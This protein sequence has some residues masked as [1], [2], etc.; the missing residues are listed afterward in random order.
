M[1]EHGPDTIVDDRY[2]ILT[3]IGAGGM[4]EVFCAHDESLGRKVA[5]KLLHRRFA[6]DAEF[7]ERFRREAS[8]AAGLQHPNVV[9][10]Y[11]RGRWDG[12][13]YIAMEYLPGRT[14]KDIVRDEAPLDPV[15][16]I[17]L[18]VQVLKAARFAHRR[19]V[20]HR[21]LK[22]HNVI[23][24]DEDRAK[25]ADFGIARAGA[26][27]MT[28]TGSIMGTAQYLSPEQAQGQAVTGQSDLYSI[29]VILYELLTG[30]VP[31]QA[32]SAVSIALKHVS[33]PPTPPSALAPGVPPELE[34]VVLWALAK[35]PADR[36]PDADAF[37][38]ALEQVR[39]QLLAAAPG[40]QR[41]AHFAPL[42]VAPAAP[43][44]P[45][46]TGAAEVPGP[47]ARRRRPP[48]WAWLLALVAL[49][50]VAAAVA[51]LTRPGTVVVPDVVGREYQAATARLERAGLEV[52]IRRVFSA[53]P[54]DEVV[55]QAPRARQRV[56]EGST[57]VLSVSRGPGTID[58]P[59]VDGMTVAKAKARLQ[60]DGLTVGATIE[61]ASD[62]VAAGLVIRTSPPAGRDVRKGTS[63]NLYVSTGP[64]LVTVPSVVG[65]ARADAEAR[66]G[67]A[68]L[69]ARAVEEPS[70]EVPAGAV[71]R[72][73]PAPDAAVAPGSTVELVV[74]SGPPRVRVPGVVGQPAADAAAALAD[75]GLQVRRS[76]VPVE[77]PAQD[78]VVIDQRP[79]AGEEAPEGAPVR[80][81]VGRAVAPAPDD[82]GADDGPAEPRTPGARFQRPGRGDGPGRGNAFGRFVGAG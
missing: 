50:G 59:A 15:R 48:W 10:I 3:R 12:T 55:A 11:D 39:D 80:I 79:A 35:D 70:A 82:G 40:G 29:G 21:D 43:A 78:G 9:G 38:R 44:A 7:V 66:L 64:A 81:F 24:D 75:A 46:A 69:E 60:N 26:S 17:D 49:A 22:P 63:V 71:I 76:L 2:R 56:E 77:D 37:I 67:E 45:P 25:V 74:S 68:G 4:A 5:L 18:T 19:G 73:Q 62:S 8:A 53:R 57:V 6:D 33:E 58:V 52:R 65:L 36:P 14:L 30:Q 1:S 51:L 27:D 23:V 28:E 20:V 31:F 13:Y 61:E 41:T 47:A 34:D 72:Q 54:L 16:A 42:P 32:D